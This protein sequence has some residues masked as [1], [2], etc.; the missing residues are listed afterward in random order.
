MEMVNPV[1]RSD[2]ASPH[3]GGSFPLVLGDSLSL[4]TPAKVNW[5]L[6]ITGKRK[7][8]YH[9]IVSLMQCISLYDEL[10]FYHADSIAVE[11][12]IGIPVS[13]NLVYKAAALLKTCVSYRKGVR[14]VVKKHI[15]VSAGLGGGSSDAAC[16]L[17]G[18]NTL[19]GLGLQNQELSS[20]GAQI[21]SDIPF[22]FNSPAA[23][24]EGK[25]DRVNSLKIGPSLVLLLVKPHV[26][27]STAWAYAAFDRLHG[28]TLTK[29]PIDIKL[30]CQALGKQDFFS[31]SK[32][33]SNDLEDVVMREYPAVSEIKHQ[34]TEM[35]ARVAAMSGSGPTVFGVFR[36]KEEAVKAAAAMKPSWCGVVET[37]I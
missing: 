6:R 14:I 37:L 33:L 9:D 31:L 32:I 26:K 1:K 36:D 35:G 20:I 16:T 3:A 23:L 25:G 17:S 10:I 30:F 27:V 7:D 4:R 21:G 12:D 13:D 34:L 5:F 24:V 11:S 29:K 8:G 18:L 22:F 2:S 28:S 15:P 19:W